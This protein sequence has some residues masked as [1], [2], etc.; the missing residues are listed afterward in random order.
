MKLITRTQEF[1]KLPSHLETRRSPFNHDSESRTRVRSTK[2]LQIFLICR[3]SR[4]LPVLTTGLPVLTMVAVA[5]SNRVFPPPSPC[6]FSGG[7]R[8]R[9]C[10]PSNV[11]E[12]VTIDLMFK[13]GT[14]S[15]VYTQT[16]FLGDTGSIVQTRQEKIDRARSTNM[17]KTRT[18]RFKIFSSQQRR[19][20]RRNFYVTI[21]SLEE[22]RVFVTCH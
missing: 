19:T 18:V 5:R 10:Q 7:R 12:S 11:T 21:F 13:D 9:G 15:T 17:Q 22:K 2:L 16:T 3:I 6:F 14:S 4:E 1:A 20:K 8:F